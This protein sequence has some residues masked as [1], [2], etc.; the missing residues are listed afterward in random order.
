MW[1]FIKQWADVLI[2]LPASFALLVF[3][4][5]WVKYLDPTAASMSAENL[6][7]I[8]FNIF[9]ITVIFGIAYFLYNVFFHDFFDKGW[10][11]AKLP[12]NPVAAA[13]IHLVLWLSTLAAVAFLVLRGI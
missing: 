11:K 9:V 10:E 4:D 2:L 13:V 8:N 3:N 5:K 12:D 6:S 7:V 1:K